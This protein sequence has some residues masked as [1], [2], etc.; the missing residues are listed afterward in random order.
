MSDT[1]VD[2]ID[3]DLVER[4]MIS[5]YNG[6]YRVPGG[7][8]MCIVARKA[9]PARYDALANSVWDRCSGRKK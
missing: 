5:V 3:W 4:Q 6:S 2:V 7:A 1:K 8:A 9:D